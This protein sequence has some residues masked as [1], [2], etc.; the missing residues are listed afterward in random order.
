MIACFGFPGRV[1]FGA[2]KGPFDRYQ[3]RIYCSVLKKQVKDN[4][5]L[6]G[7]PQNKSCAKNVVF[8]KSTKTTEM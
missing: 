6:V 5:K 8:D 1:R 4:K 2:L 7:V 3:P